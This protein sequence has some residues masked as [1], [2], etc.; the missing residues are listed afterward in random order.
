MKPP[1]RSFHAE[2]RD[3]EEL[4]KVLREASRCN[5]GAIHEKNWA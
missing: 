5:L 2:S 3:L 4:S 1:W